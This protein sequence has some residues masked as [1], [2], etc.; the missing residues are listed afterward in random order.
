MIGEIFRHHSSG[1]NLRQVNKQTAKKAYE[2]GQTVYLLPS[3]CGF[4]NPW[5]NPSPMRQEDEQWSSDNF[6]SRVNEYQYY[7]CNY[8]TG[9][10]PHYYVEVN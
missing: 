6:N 9:Y 2:A 1:K 10:Y 5:I 4:V 7:N 8:G 3:N